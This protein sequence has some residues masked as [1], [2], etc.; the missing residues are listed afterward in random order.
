MVETITPVVYGTRTRWAIAFLL[1]VVGAT[2]TAALFGA[3]L[4]AVGALLDAPWGRAGA[5]VLALAAVV[6][7]LGELPRVTA[8]VPQLRRQVP[9]WW[10]EFFSWPAA[11]A[12]YGAG[13]GVGF[14]TYLSHG[15]LVVV[16]LG[17]VATGDALVGALV[18]APFGLARGLSAA[19]ASG[20]GTQQESQDLV[21]RLAGSP[22]RRRAI[23]NG[24]SLIAIAALA[25]TAAVSATDGWA[26]LAT[27]VLALAFA[28][29]ALSKAAGLREWRRT[30]AAHALP[31]RVEAAAI[32]GVPLAEALVPVLAVCGWTRASGVW[33]LVLIVVFT[34]EALRAWNRFGAQVPC[35]C[36][37][38]REPVTPPALLLR[39]VGLAA[40]AIV[41]AL[42]PP[43]EPTF[44]WPGWPMPSEYLP[45]VLVIAGVAV[46]VCT[47]W[48]AIRWLGR[49]VRP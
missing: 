37:G 12:L 42:R 10:R 38:G 15:T 46:A 16:S 13:L 17:A 32:A 41:V 47:A 36:F 27:A 39:N 31:G 43:P 30:I 1:H 5:L 24:V 9:D 3:T 26:A 20:V 49:G 25:T 8:T 44:A 35:G 18:V 34:A 19:R 11:A 21:D 2:A 48:T 40:T 29:A 45:M 4:G 33:A 14:F 6:Y 28:Y 22:E 7:A 23:A